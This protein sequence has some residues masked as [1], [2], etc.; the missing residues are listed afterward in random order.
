MHIKHCCSP[1]HLA[2][3]YPH[4][5]PLQNATSNL[6]FNYNMQFLYAAKAQVHGA[7]L[8]LH[9]SKAHVTFSLRI[10][11]LLNT[12]SKTKKHFLNMDVIQPSTPPPTSH[13]VSAGPVPTP[14]S[15]NVSVTPVISAVDDTSL[16][17]DHVD[18]SVM[19]IDESAVARAAQ[20]AASAVH[21]PGEAPTHVADAE[22]P[23]VMFDNAQTPSTIPK[24]KPHERYHASAEQLKHLVAAFETN[25]TPGTKT[26]TYLCKTTGMPMHNL[27]LWFKN[28]RARH[29][30]SQ[31][32]PSNPSGKRSYVKSGIYSKGARNR[33]TAMDLDL[34]MGSDKVTPALRFPDE[35]SFK[36]HADDP[37][38]PTEKTAKKARF[39]YSRN[40]PDFTTTN[41]RACYSWDWREC[42][43][44]CMSFYYNAV[45]REYPAQMSI[46]SIVMRHFFEGQTQNGITLT[47]DMQNLDL[48]VS[49]LQ[50][51]IREK[52][53]E[54]TWGSKTLL[55]EFLAMMRYGQAV[56]IQ[57]VKGIGLDEETEGGMEADVMEAVHM[58]MREE[59]AEPQETGVDD[60]KKPDSSAA[61]LN[62]KVEEEED[63]GHS[64]GDPSAEQTVAAVATRGAVAEQVDAVEETEG[65]GA[66][67][68][69]A[70]DA[71][72]AD[73]TGEGEQVEPDHVVG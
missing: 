45:G 28:R 36:R 33:A 50:Q 21:V 8:A 69:E 32:A 20:R 60:G 71:G 22:D 4:K 29:R 26:L 62:P 72:V 58:D 3:L 11:S 41:P 49:I 43:R 15:P 64:Q 31:G 10:S 51:I 53:P 17:T 37:E 73:D 39:G 13:P 18:V 6:D 40:P 30:K 25:P 16:H 12:K 55:K 19:P 35:A 56:D 66:E 14:S 67:Q 61:E 34:E 68:T 2:G 46:A 48:S 5:L 54:L 38:I 44:R 65:E 1:I 59:Q 52:G 23:N 27:V 7:V 63:S 24:R 9:K 57:V 42:Y 70:E 47:S